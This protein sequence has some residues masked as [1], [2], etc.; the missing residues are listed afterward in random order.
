MSEEDK[1]GI[2]ALTGTISGV[3]QPIQKSIFKA[4]G[5]LLDGLIELPVAKLNQ[6]TQAINDKTEA[7]KITASVLAKAAADKM[8]NDQK[9]V[10]IAAE[11]YLPTAVR[12]IKN[13][14]N[15]AQCAADHL[16][17]KVHEVDLDR[18]KSPDENWMNNFMRYA[19]DAS[20]EELQD[21]MGRLLAGEVLN[22]GAYSLA[23]LRTLN[24]L[25]SNLATDF[26]EAWSKSV[27]ETVGYSEEW[28]RGSGYERWRRLIEA[29]L[30]SSS[31]S[32]RYTPE[33]ASNGIG[34]WSP[35]RTNDTWINIMFRKESTA[36]WTHIPFTRIGREIATLLPKPDYKNNIRQAALR[37]QKQGLVSITL[38]TA[39]GDTELLWKEQ[40]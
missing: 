39:A 21:R 40:V 7:N 33:I 17:D 11:A 14:L 3:P 37:I 15:V 8:V 27:G 30:M 24:E 20:S 2:D 18:T 38:E 23:T 34:L 28:E 12:K 1:S 16:K 26:L 5:T 13:R 4:I 36:N 32:I 19:E 31:T 6:L 9:L 35:M 29:G 10:D 22:P 25:D